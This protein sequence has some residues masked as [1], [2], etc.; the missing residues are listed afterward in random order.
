MARGDGVVLRVQDGTSMFTYYS[1]FTDRWPGAAYVESVLLIIMMTTAIIG[2]IL[3]IV[4]VTRYRKMRTVTN[5]FV[6]SLAISDLL[7]ATH[8]PII[9][10]T[11]ITVDW[12]IGDI[13]C[14]LVDY[15]MFVSAI[16]SILTLMVISIDR[17]IVICVSSRN[18][19]TRRRGA[20]WIAATWLVSIVFS[21]PIA[22]THMVHHVYQDDTI[23]VFCHI[24]WPDWFNGLWYLAPFAICFFFLPLGVM[25]YSYVKVFQTVKKSHARL[26]AIG[27]KQNR[28][29]A[30]EGRKHRASED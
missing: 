4:S 21:V 16:N 13:P 9:I 26:A 6:L 18:R 17:R 5:Y 2:N 25:V 15:M 1:D 24:V 10:I 19:M 11:R 27:G 8:V 20:Q 23:Y 29:V 3:V 30:L 22:L 14:K 7:F 28:K 12:V